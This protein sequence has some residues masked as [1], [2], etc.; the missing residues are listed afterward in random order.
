MKVGV[1][2]FLDPVLWGPPQVRSGIGGNPVPQQ[3]AG[4]HRPDALPL[5]SGHRQRAAPTLGEELRRAV[6]GRPRVRGHDG[7]A[8]DLGDAHHAFWCLPAVG[9]AQFSVAG[10]MAGR[11]GCA[12]R[13]AAG[14]TRPR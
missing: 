6:D 1:M 13:A 5:G 3:I 11:H 8:H 12:G 9:V 7:A 10:F 2:T 4:A 14:S